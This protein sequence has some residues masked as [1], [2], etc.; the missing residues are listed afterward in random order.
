MIETGL[1]VGGPGNLDHPEKQAVVG[2]IPLLKT[3]EVKSLPFQM[4]IHP[5][6]RRPVFFIDQIDQ[7]ICPI[8]QHCLVG[9]IH[10]IHTLLWLITFTLYSL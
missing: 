3:G 2:V 7:G 9:E 4:I 5:P 6:Q 8:K 1:S 10:A